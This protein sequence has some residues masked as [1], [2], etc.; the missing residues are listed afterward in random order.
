MHIL[1]LRIEF[2][3]AALQVCLRGRRFVIHVVCV[4][5]FLPVRVC[6]CLMASGRPSFQSGMLRMRLRMAFDSPSNWMNFKA[7]CLW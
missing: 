6:F 2:P 3:A 1:S 7:E 5:G 4:L